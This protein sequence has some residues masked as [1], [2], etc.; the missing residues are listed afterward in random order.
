MSDDEGAYGGASGQGRVSSAPGYFP[1]SADLPGQLTRSPSVSSV[2]SATSKRRRVVDDDGDDVVMEEDKIAD[3]RLLRD[4]IKRLVQG[5]PS[6]ISKSTQKSLLEKWTMAEDLLMNTIVEN[7][8]MRKEIALLREFKERPAPVPAPQMRSFAD[9][10]KTSAKIPVPVTI[11]RPKPNVVILRPTPDGPIKTADEVKSYFVKEA[12]P[13]L[14]GVRIRNVRRVR[15]EGLLLETDR[16]SDLRKVRER[17]DAGLKDVKVEE[18]KTIGPKLI[19][20]GVP[21]DIKDDDLANDVYYR[22][23]NPDVMTVEDF[24]KGFQV[25][26]RNIAKDRVSS[27]RANVVVEVNGAIRRLLL[28]GDRIYIDFG[29]HH[30]R[31]FD[32]VTRCYRCLSFGHVAKN[33]R[34]KDSTCRHCSEVGHQIGDCP[35]KNSPPK[36]RNCFIKGKDA[37]HSISDGCC[38]EYARA[39]IAQRQKISYQ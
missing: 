17:V 15:N 33:C 30:V 2:G 1:M 18:P 16:E 4:Q 34:S 31:D 26:Y 8:L 10:L 7:K 32:M 24:C 19:I 3:L 35:S 27:G 36:C 5:D 25:R 9:A 11:P 37:S 38:P 29:S 21:N 39:V 20:F 12:L 28:S 14:K 22:N 13:E 6:K 23:I